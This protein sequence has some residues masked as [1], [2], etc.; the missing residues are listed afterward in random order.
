MVTSMAP[1]NHTASD[2]SEACHFCTNLPRP[3]WQVP[4]PGEEI[5][6]FEPLAGQPEARADNGDPVPQYNG[7]F[8]PLPAGYSS[9]YLRT[10]YCVFNGIRPGI[11]AD[12]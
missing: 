11:Y 1:G 6:V 5:P 3:V 10:W 4:A 7:P 12:W 9:P 2:T 8:P